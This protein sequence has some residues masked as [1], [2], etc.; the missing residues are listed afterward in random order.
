MQRYNPFT[1][2]H[3]ALRAMLYDASLTIQQTYFAHPEEAEGALK[4]IEDVLFLIEQHGHH[5][6]TGL[7]PAIEMCAPGVVEKFEDE[8]VTDHNLSSRLKH[9]LNIFRSAENEP[10]KILCGS[11]IS[12]AF[13]EFMVFN[14]EHMA[15]EELLI[16]AALWKEYS[17]EQIQLLTQK[18][19]TNIPPAEK[20]LSAKWILRGVN[21]IEA[22]QWLKQVKATVP[23]TLFEKILGIA[24]AE[25]PEITREK[26]L[27]GV[28]ET[29]LA[30]N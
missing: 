15:K 13:V 22:I 20:A 17:D 29:E 25:L 18:M 1:Y 21:H 11:A 10:D 26:V 7:L 24:E 8:H 16:N 23:A 14:L 3:K 12:K 9:L 2:I 4:K 5:E 6:D 28:W 27:D 19:R 30:A